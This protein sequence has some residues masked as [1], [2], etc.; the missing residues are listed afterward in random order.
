METILQVRLYLTRGSISG[1]LAYMYETETLPTEPS[2][3]VKGDVA[4]ERT[5]TCA[6]NYNLQILIQVCAF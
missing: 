6:L 5:I 1:P 2:C 4:I 3:L